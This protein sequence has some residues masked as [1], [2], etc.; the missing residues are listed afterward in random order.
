MAY[1]IF[2][3]Y[4]ASAWRFSIHHKKITKIKSY[5]LNHSNGSGEKVDKAQY[6]L[7]ENHFLKH[8]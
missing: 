7:N 6:V 5:V 3:H 4:L 8:T 2:V 1:R